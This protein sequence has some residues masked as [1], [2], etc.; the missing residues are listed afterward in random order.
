MNTLNKIALITGGTTGIGAATAKRFQAE[1]ATVIVTGSNKATLEAA[2]KA[3][4]EVEVVASD[5]GDPAATKML[6]DQVQAKHGRIDVLFV[7]AGIARM[8]LSSTVNEA[9][10]D[11]SSTSTCAARTSS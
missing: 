4:P 7:N 3:M 6:I 10:F 5:A 2:R 11:A 1:G 9:F 8:A